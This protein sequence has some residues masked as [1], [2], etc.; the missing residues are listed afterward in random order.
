MVV[1][2]RR[3]TAKGN[4]DEEEEEEEEV[5]KLRCMTSLNLV[6]RSNILPPLFYLLFS[7][8]TTV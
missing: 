5:S 7:F 2:T 8:H 6:I 4:D 1:E 3:I